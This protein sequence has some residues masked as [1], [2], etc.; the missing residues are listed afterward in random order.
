MQYLLNGHLAADL[1]KPSR[2]SSET[3]YAL[4]NNLYAHCR[5]DPNPYQLLDL[6]DLY[7][8][9]NYAGYIV[10]AEYGRRD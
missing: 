4:Q 6:A 8:I 3:A 5:L 7:A 1:E 9:C 10:F 2:S